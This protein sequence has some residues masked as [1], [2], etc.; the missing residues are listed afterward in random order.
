M[1]IVFIAAE[2]APVWQRPVLLGLLVVSVILCAFWLIKSL[3]KGGP[4][5]GAVEIEERPGLAELALMLICLAL[6]SL[7]FSWLCKGLLGSK[8]LEAASGASLG[9]LLSCLL[10]LG[11]LSWRNPG[12]LKSLGL[13]LT[14]CPRQLGWGLITALAVWPIATLV[15]MPAS[16]WVVKFV[17][18]WGWGLS[19]TLQSHTLLRELNESTSLLSVYLTIVIAV[20]IAPLTE[21]IIFRGLLQ[22]ALARLYRSRW[23]AIVVSAAIFSIF[24]LTL[25][26]NVAMGEASLAHVEKIPPLFLLGLALGYSYEKS[27]SLY[28]PIWIHLGFNA[29]SLLMLWPKPA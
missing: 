28:R 14:Q 1:S 8:D 27:R 11:Y 15:L 17:L 24:H 29:L 6:L 12:R 22:G 25:R 19:Y 23:A 13:K 10:V 4:L 16:F 26:E 9:S 5:R 21:E 7:G 2:P 20:I 18:N 3:V